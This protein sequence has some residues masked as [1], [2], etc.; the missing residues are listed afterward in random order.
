MMKKIL[1]LNHFPTVYPP[2]SGGTLRYFHIYNELSQYYDITL[3][4]QTHGRKG[5][6]FQFS[7]TFREYKV[8]KDPRHQQIMQVLQNGEATYEFSL[9]INV[10]L[11][12]HLTLYKKYF[13]DLYRTSD[14]IIHE[15]PYMLGYDQ[16][17]GLDDKPRIYNS[18]NHEYALAHQI[19]ENQKAR[20]YLPSI[21][22]LE[23]KL[24]ED[25]DLVFATSEIEKDNFVSMYNLDPKKV[26][27]A[28]NG[29]HPDEWLQNKKKSNINPKAFFIG[30]EYP[31]NIEAVGYIIHHLADK[32]PDIEFMIAGGCC[33]PFSKLK[34][35][36]VHL[37]GRVH[38]KQKLKLFA[39]VDIAINPMFT[40]A[41]VN[42]K[43]LEFLSAGIP[44]FST[45][46]GARGLN[47]IEEQHY[48]HAEKEDFAEK[49][50]QFCHDKKYLQEISSSGQKYIND[51][52]SWGNI[53]KS[54]QEELEEIIPF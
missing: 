17:L 10:E 32:C 41:G 28:P 4:S 27:V 29:I 45:H 35:S 19:W 36:N 53:A 40:G 39:D 22:E 43:T 14:I 2:T 26:K 30:A 49:I 18:Q 12:N 6:L 25:A 47:L 33:N 34:K 16:N 23:K 7:S 11:S 44:L 15:S 42:L 54:I 9:I 46:C 21:Y 3:L 50:N 37:F 52:Y 13:D 48:I 31:P 5:G 24:T 20:K 51:N 38:H 8:E 1:V